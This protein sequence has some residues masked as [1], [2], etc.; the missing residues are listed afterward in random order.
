MKA[1]KDLED[2]EVLKEKDQT[3]TFGTACSI[4]EVASLSCIVSVK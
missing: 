1:V 4:E 2:Q 3:Q